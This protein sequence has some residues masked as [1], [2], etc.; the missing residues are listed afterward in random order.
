MARSVNDRLFHLRWMGSGVDG[1]LPEKMGNQT[2]LFL[3]GVHSLNVPEIHFDY[4]ARKGVIVPVFQG[5]RHSVRRQTR[6]QTLQELK[7]V[8]SAQRFKVKIACP[9]RM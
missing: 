2:E 9:G 1:G 4:V 7:R 3:H 6:P 8:R 5:I